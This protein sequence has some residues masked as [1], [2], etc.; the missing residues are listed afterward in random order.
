MR[1]VLMT[2]MQIHGVRR[3]KA[4]FFFY[5][6][7]CLFFCF[8]TTLLAQ[9]KLDSL[10]L[11][12]DFQF[13]NGLYTDVA[14]LRTN[15][16]KVLLET[17]GGSLVFME[18]SVLLKIEELH[19][20]GYPN[21]TYDLNTIEVIVYQGLPF[22]RIDQDSTRGFTVYA[23]LRVRGRLSYFSYEQ[24]YTDS[25]LI[26]AYNPATGKPFRQQKMARDQVTQMRKVVNLATGE[27]CDFELDNMYHLLADDPSLIKTLRAMPLEEARQKIERFLLI[28][29][30]RNPLY[31]P[32]IT[33]NKPIDD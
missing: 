33:E 3:K 24:S 15:R 28:Y 8:E 10:P 30:D 14:E 18:N 26:S 31:L 21:S 25:V 11:D 7:L 32:K 6:S 29:D 19:P 16:P 2:E 17:L 23:G 27:R 13:T 9:T 4:S 12:K 22:F 5:I 1:K 20:K